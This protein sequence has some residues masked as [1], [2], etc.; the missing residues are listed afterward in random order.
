[1][2][3]PESDID[4]EG[5]TPFRMIFPAPLQSTDSR[6]CRL[7]EIFGLPCKRPRLRPLDSQPQVHP[8]IG[9][10]PARV[11]NALTLM[12]FLRCDETIL[13]GLALSLV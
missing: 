6:S 3:M 12:S 5:V 10:P 11:A 9:A 13:S 8:R 2:R 7:C 4:R 1:M